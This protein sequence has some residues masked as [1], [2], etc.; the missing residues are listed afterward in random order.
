MGILGNLPDAGNAEQEFKKI[1]KGTYVCGLSDC[2]LSEVNVSGEDIK[3][4]KIE[5]KILKGEFKGR[6]LWQ[7][8]W[9]QEPNT[10]GR[11]TA[12]AITMKTFNIGK[13]KNGNDFDNW[14]ELAEHAAS[15]IFDKVSK[16][17]YKVTIYGHRLYNEQEYPM[18]SASQEIVELGHESKVNPGVKNHAPK[19]SVPAPSNNFDE[20]EEIPF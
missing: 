17:K 13:D 7:T 1:P 9:F 6:K 14:S 19:P 15:I 10:D 4:I 18:C 16:A 12:F 2:E 20:D 11:R 5:Y 3:I 8:V